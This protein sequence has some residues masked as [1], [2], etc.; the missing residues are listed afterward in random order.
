MMYDIAI[1]Q[2]TYLPWAGY[3]NLM[4]SVETFV[5]LD[6][7]EFSKSSWHSRNQLNIS[8]DAHWISLPIKHSDHQLIKNTSIRREAGWPR[9]HINQIECN[10]KKAKHFN[11]VEC[12]IEW[13]K[14]CDSDNLA[15]VNIELIT[16][17]ADKLNIQ[18]DIKLSSELNI[19]A[20]RSEKLKQIIQ[21]FEAQNY[22]S[23]IGS[24]EY[25]EQ[26]GILGQAGINVVYQN[27]VPGSYQQLRTLQWNS[28]MS[29]IDVVANLGWQHAKN[30][31]RG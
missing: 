9:K 26:D 29:I 30:Y 23:P 11:D 28:H 14:T 18:C 31:I 21:H 6:D 2:P 7:A 5:F 12:V 17:I 13:L 27:Y 16:L 22:F 1:M 20:E 24:K 8:G 19:N 4:A 15:R 3:F 25:I 10:Y